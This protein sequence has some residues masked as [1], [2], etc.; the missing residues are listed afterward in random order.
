MVLTVI[1]IIFVGL[2]C[3]VMG[4][5]L[6]CAVTTDQFLNEEKKKEG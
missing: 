3:T 6:G 5:L 4:Y 1:T 2:W